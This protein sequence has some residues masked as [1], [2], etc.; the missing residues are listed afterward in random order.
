MQQMQQ[1][2]GQMQGQQRDEGDGGEEEG[3]MDQDPGSIDIPAPEDFQT[4][5]AYRRALLEGMAGDVP[6]EYR[7]MKQQYFEELVRQ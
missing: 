2:R 1:A 6:E 4:P 7:S 5:E 3:P